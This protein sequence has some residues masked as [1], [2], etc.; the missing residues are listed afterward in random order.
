M[1]AVMWGLYRRAWQLREKLQLDP[2]EQLWT[3]V[4]M[5]NWALVPVVAAVSITLALAI[6]ATRESG[7]L[8]GLPGF[9]FFVLNL[10]ELMLRRWLAKRL[11]T[12][13]AQ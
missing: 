4:R 9:V 10:T 8:L 11:Q 13:E 3:R 6:P 1:G 2:R 7:W 5:Y 12:L